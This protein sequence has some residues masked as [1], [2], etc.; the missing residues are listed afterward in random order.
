MRVT[1]AIRDYVEA[2]INKK[3]DDAANEIG[4]EYF[5]EKEQVEKEIRKI[6]QE[7]SAKAEEYAVSKGFTTRNCYRSSCLFSFDGGIGKQ[8][9]ENN[10]YATRREL[11][12]KAKSKTNQVLFDLEM[13]ETNKAK[14]REVLDNIAVE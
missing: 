3:Y 12:M 9:L 13:G 7:A 14:L 1:K 2:E 5:A 8:E 11:Q 10:I 4:K 6:M